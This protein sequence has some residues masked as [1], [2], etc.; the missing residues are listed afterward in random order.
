MRS[1]LYKFCRLFK[2]EKWFFSLGLLF[3]IFNFLESAEKPFV[4]VV[5]SYNNEKFV[6]KNIGSILAQKYRN[7]RVVYFDDAST[8]KTYEKVVSQLRNSYLKTK[9]R[10][11]SN[12]RNKG[13]MHNHYTAISSC[14]EKEIV[15]ILDGDDWFAHAGVLSYLNQ[16]Y[17]DPH[18]WMTWGNYSTYPGNN[19][20]LSSKIRN[21]NTI[22]LR[23][24]P[25]VTSHLRSFYAGLFHKIDRQDFCYKG[26]FLETACDL[27]EMFP[28][29][30]MARD[31]A[32]FIPQILY[33]YNDENSLND[34]KT[35]PLIQTKMTQFIRSKKPYQKLIELF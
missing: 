31:H 34:H 11:I 18:T 30:E 4:I 32:I 29:I 17:Q 13:A 9:F 27:A 1:N 15:V 2:I 14:K 12:A 21:I 6:E 19:R 10:V 22:D 5:A 24:S 35:I 7:F 26:Q 23:K 28:M 8:D 25:W 3:L 16:V 20:G 33:I